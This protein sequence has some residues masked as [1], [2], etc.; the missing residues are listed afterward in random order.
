MIHSQ[1]GCQEAE[2]APAYMFDLNELF[3]EFEGL[4]CPKI[5]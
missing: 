5:N 2:V 3:W 4:R 1:Y